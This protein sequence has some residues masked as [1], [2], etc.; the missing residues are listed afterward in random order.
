MKAGS[1]GMA[2]ELL[3]LPRDILLRF[4][5]HLDCAS[6]ASLAQTC[7]SMREVVAMEEP[8]LHLCTTLPSVPPAVAQRWRAR[9]DSARSLF[10]LLRSLEPLV[11]VWGAE[12]LAPRGGLLYITWVS[13]FPSSPLMCPLTPL[14]R[15]AQACALS[16][17]GVTWVTTPSTRSYSTTQLFTE[18]SVGACCRQIR[19]QSGLSAIKISAFRFLCNQVSL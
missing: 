8:W 13:P 1:G 6:L 17:V 9:A 2:M 14:P 18:L 15:G 5:M 19:L 4:C 16:G 3:D 11:G 7:S 10:R 12:N